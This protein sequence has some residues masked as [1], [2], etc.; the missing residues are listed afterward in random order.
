MKKNGAQLL[1][2]SLEK[3]GITT[4]A[5]IPGGNILPIYDAMGK[6]KIRH[7]LAKHEQGAAFIAQGMARVTRKPA[8][9][10]ATSGPGAMNLITALADAYGDSCPL[11]T[12][13][14][15]VAFEMIGKEAF[16]EVDICSMAKTVTKQVFFIHK[17]EEISVIVRN[18]FH[19]ANNGRPGPVL[20][21]IPKD[22]QL[23]LVDNEFV[24]SFDER[25]GFKNLPDGNL[26]NE[27]VELIKTARRP[28][29][30]AGNGALVSHSQEL[31]Q[32]FAEQNSI[33]VTSTLHGLSVLPY[34]HPLYLG[35]AGVHGA[36]SANKIIREADLILAFGI[37]FDD[38]LVGKVDE[39]CPDA[40]IIH[41]D[42]SKSQFGKIIK[43][44][45]AIQCDL[46]M[47]LEII[48]KR[49]K[50]RKNNSMESDIKL[51]HRSEG[52]K[53]NDPEFNSIYP[54]SFLHQIQKLIPN[55]AIIVTDVGQHQMWVAQYYPFLQ[56]QTFL[57]SGGQGTM[58]FGLPA[59]IGASIAEPDK[60]VVLFTGDGSLLMNI[61]ELA[62]LHEYVCNVT[63][64]VMN[65]SQLGMVRQQQEM[66]YN[67]NYC[68]SYFQ[69]RFSFAEIA[70]GFGINSCE[71]GDS[72]YNVN[73]LK[74]L[75][76]PSGP[77]VID[78]TV[79]GNGNILPMVI[80]GKANINMYEYQNIQSK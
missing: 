12:I 18:A 40:K 41:I 36:K 74:G 32:Q 8:V 53:S 38:R 26:V 71:I 11:I 31:I 3:E 59:A 39:F 57:S 45:I 15:Q 50:P 44:D 27:A 42:I 78:V 24:H 47:A 69:G 72:L 29:I 76:L 1:I 52:H 55:D 10:M 80:P 65:N 37:R 73:A 68:G 14:G 9:C 5:G 61:Q 35:M 25:N 51:I 23:S 20:I 19:I 4:V 48:I 77:C 49:I 22:V 62:T 70:K 6:S 79:S 43:P 17:A 16:Q 66:F 7:I 33:P 75:L 56:S 21:D 54:V 67:E 63:V 34:E 46:K 64:F 60:K 2:E 58:G 13:T 28:V 30:I